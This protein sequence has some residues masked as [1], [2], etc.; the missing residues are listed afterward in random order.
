MLTYKHLEHVANRLGYCF[1]ESDAGNK[2]L[3]QIL[4]KV[5]RVVY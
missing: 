1:G 3:R 5:K 4:R 2:V